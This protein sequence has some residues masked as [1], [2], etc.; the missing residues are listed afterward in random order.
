[1]ILEV[2]SSNL[3]ADHIV[4]PI[5]I[6]PLLCLLVSLTHTRL[7]LFGSVLRK[8]RKAVGPVVKL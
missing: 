8:A 1:M 6:P 7:F 3:N 2:V 4:L 5:M